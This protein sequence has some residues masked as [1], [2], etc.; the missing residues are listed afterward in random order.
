MDFRN[1]LIPLECVG[2]GHVVTELQ[3]NKN[4]C[5]IQGLQNSVWQDTCLKYG[6]RKLKK[7]GNG[8]ARSALNGARDAK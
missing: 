7:Q 6:P 5:C 1:V 4:P 8:R 2:E 3:K